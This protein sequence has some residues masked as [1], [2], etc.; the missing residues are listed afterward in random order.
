MKYLKVMV[1]LHAD[2]IVF[3]ITRDINTLLITAEI[4]R[5]LNLF[6]MHSHW[7]LVTSVVIPCHIEKIGD[8]PPEKSDN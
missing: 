5:K 1:S 2:D 3:Q 8:T 7:F 4:I 6:N